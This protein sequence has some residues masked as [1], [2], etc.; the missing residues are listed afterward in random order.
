MHEAAVPYRL[1][2][3]QIP[4]MGLGV[5]HDAWASRDSRAASLAACSWFHW[6]FVGMAVIAVI[7]GRRRHRKES[8][9]VR[10]SASARSV[11]LDGV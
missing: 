5:V 4:A 11:A 1:I 10:L 3:R 8:S 6:R 2:A 9:M 7:G